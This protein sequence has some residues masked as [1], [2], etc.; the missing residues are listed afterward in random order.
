[1]YTTYKHAQSAYL[2][3]AIVLLHKV[4]GQCLLQASMYKCIEKKCAKCTKNVSKFSFTD[5]FLTAQC[6]SALFT[7]S[8]YVHV[9]EFNTNYYSQK[10]VS[11]VSFVNIDPHWGNIRTV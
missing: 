6:K 9:S 11:S 1:M 10:Q 2:Q 3:T 7:Q 5:Y 8:K 4:K